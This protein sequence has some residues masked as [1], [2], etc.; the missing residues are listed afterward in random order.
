M[1]KLKESLHTAAVKNAVPHMSKQEDT[2][3]PPGTPVSLPFV[4]PGNSMIYVMTWSNV[5]RYYVVFAM[6]FHVLGWVC[7]FT[8]A[9]FCLLKYVCPP[10]FLLPCTI[11]NAILQA[12]G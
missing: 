1:N 2:D 8:R 12:V 10:L 7:Y 9:M 4:S 3:T 5:A 6:W 11:Y